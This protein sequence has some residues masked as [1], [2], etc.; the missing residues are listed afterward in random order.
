MTVSYTHL[1]VYKRQIEYRALS[2]AVRDREHAIFNALRF[3]EA[4]TAIVFCKTRV[5]VNHLM[6]RMGNRGFKVVALSGELSQQERTNALTALR[7]LSLIH[8]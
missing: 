5:N 6:A 8:I 1:D 2:V 4:K 7:N 3:Y